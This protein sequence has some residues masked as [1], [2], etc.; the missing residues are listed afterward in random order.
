GWD[1]FWAWPGPNSRAEPQ[2]WAC[3]AER[4]L[5]SLGERVAIPRHF[6]P[7]SLKLSDLG[8]WSS[9]SET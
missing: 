4:G 9:L 8:R 3:V 6:S 5:S 7:E 1:G 2:I